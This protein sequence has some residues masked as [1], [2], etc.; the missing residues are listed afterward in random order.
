MEYMGVTFENVDHLTDWLDEVLDADYEIEYVLEDIV[1]YYLFNGFDF[2]ELDDELTK[3]RM[4]ETY[5][6]RIEK[7]Y[8]DED[9]EEEKEPKITIYF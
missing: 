5:W 9:E 7:E 3:S 8:D 2:Y 6:F 1:G 4:L